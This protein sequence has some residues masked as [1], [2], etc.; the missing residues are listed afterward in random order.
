MSER[1]LAPL[2]TEQFK[3]SGRRDIQRSESFDDVGE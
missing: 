3:L 1:S 2:S